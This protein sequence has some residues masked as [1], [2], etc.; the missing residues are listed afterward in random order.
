M[1]SGCKVTSERGE[2]LSSVRQVLALYTGLASVQ[3]ENQEVTR[4]PTSEL[5]FEKGGKSDETWALTYLRLEM[6]SHTCT[7]WKQMWVMSKKK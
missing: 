7:R 2:M 1:D 3:I 5:S 6:P 4:A